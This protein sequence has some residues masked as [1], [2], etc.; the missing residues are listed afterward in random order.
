MFLSEASFAFVSHLPCKHLVYI[1]LFSRC[2]EVVKLVIN[3]EKKMADLV[4]NTPPPRDYC[5]STFSKILEN[6]FLSRLSSFFLKNKVRKSK[7]YGL[8][9]ELFTTMLACILFNLSQTRDR[10][11]SCRYLLR[12]QQSIRL[13]GSFLRSE[14]TSLVLE[15]R[16]LRIETTVCC[17][18]VSREPGDFFRRSYH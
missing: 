3:H 6:C 12:P 16:F 9:A 8:R 15:N 1:G 10:Q 4:D 14:G 7:E 13:H 2:P 11:I 18:Q 5:T 17:K